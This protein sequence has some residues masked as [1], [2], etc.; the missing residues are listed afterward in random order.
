MNQST[1]T[2][3]EKNTTIVSNVEEPII[4]AIDHGYGNIKTSNF[5]FPANATLLNTGLSFS[6]DILVYDGNSYAIGM[7]HKEFRA[8]KIMDQ[9]YYLLTLAA[10]AKELDHRGVT[11]A[12][13]VIAAGLPLTWGIEQKVRFQEYLMQNAH[14]DFTYKGVHYH[15]DVQEAMV[16]NQGIAAVANQI[17]K[18]FKGTNM[19]VD[20]GNGTMN[21]MNI[22]EKTA[23]PESCF[24]EKYGTYQC[25]IRAREM[26]QRKFGSLPTDA[27][28]EKYLRSM[29][30]D[31]GEK[32]KA[33]IQETAKQYVAEIFR[34]LR[35]HEYD[36]NLMRLWVIGGGGCLVKN[37][38]EYDAEQVTFIE[39]LRANAKG[40]ERLARRALEK[41]RKKGE[42]Q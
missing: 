41:R 40:Y 4:I 39:D 22:N 12:R 11:N 17:K 16:F 29:N 9:D 20:I 7:G 30:A 27:Q 36:P 18:S 14:V 10:V 3:A 2:A 25:V 38:G 32:Y 26:L 37:F 35:E 8:N 33:V 15:V 6:D 21:V 34:R 13:I 19:L 23:I 28:I 24:T 31:I 1:I 42:Q 5:C